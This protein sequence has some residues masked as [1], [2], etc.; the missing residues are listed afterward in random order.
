M[1]PQMDGVTAALTKHAYHSS[2]NIARLPQQLS[3]S[4][5]DRDG[6]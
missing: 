3:Y 6:M 5:S 4:F 1:L 2:S